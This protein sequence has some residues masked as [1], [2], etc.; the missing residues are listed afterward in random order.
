MRNAR[1]GVL[2]VLHAIFTPG[3]EL[4]QGLRGEEGTWADGGVVMNS[5][6]HSMEAFSTYHWWR[7]AAG[8]GRNRML[9]LS[10]LL[11]DTSSSVLR[12]NGY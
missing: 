1:I 12:K 10:E 11:W 2:P 6:G 8:L 4:L 3:T 5:F 7:D 9:G